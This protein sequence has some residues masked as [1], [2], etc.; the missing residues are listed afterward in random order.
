MPTKNALATVSRM[1]F[2]GKSE[3]ELPLD[4][5]EPKWPTPIALRR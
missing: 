1:D 5:V 4:H 2:N 3:K